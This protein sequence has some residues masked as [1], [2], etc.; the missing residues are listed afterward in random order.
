MTALTALNVDR[1]VMAPCVPDAL[2]AALETGT[3]GESALTAVGCDALAPSPEPQSTDAPGPEPQSTDAPR[4][5]PPST[6]APSL[7]QPQLQTLPYVSA[8]SS[9]PLRVTAELV[10]VGSGAS[11]Q[12]SARRAL[13]AIKAADW[14]ALSPSSRAA[15]L[16][17]VADAAELTALRP[18]D[19][20]VRH[21]MEDAGGLAAAGS[22]AALEV[23]L[24]FPAGTSAG[25]LAAWGDLL[26]SA[27]FARVAASG[28]MV[29]HLASTLPS[30]AG[31]V[32]Q[33]LWALSILGRVEVPC[34]SRMSRTRF[35]TGTSGFTGLMPKPFGV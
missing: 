22:S 15:V 21:V 7:E 27:Y 23:V 18:R 13:Q 34:R 14:A 5:E 6:D 35:S 24:H 10:V 20:E 26:A 4:P 3:E 29:T 33:T 19:V 12:P 31:T 17:F 16:A 8:A 11:P 2:L 32:H 25:V 30:P 9:S 28:M 1:D